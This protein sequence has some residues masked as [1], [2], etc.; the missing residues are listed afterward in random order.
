VFFQGTEA[1]LANVPFE[2]E[3]VYRVRAVRDGKGRLGNFGADASAGQ[4][5]DFHC[6]TCY[7]EV[8]IVAAPPDDPVRLNPPKTITCRA[9]LPSIVIP[10][11]AS[12]PNPVL[13]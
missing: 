10:S 8:R 5:E 1:D 12:L 13:R 2:P 11:K 7:G 9:L 4:D 6:D 3:F